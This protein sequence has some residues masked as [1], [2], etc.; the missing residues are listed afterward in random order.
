MELLKNVQL[1]I[2]NYYKVVTEE[3][4]ITGGEELRD[5]CLSIEILAYNS[6]I[7][8]VFSF[9]DR[10][11]HVD[12]WGKSFQAEITTRNKTSKQEYDWHFLERSRIL[13]GQSKVH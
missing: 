13:C 8:L 2:I 11:I 6:L 3:L 5:D 4:Y 12:T 9:M 10:T 7:V 1:I